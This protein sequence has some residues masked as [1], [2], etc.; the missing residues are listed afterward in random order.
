MAGGG[1]IWDGT[2]G[3]DGCD[4]QKQKGGSGK[5]EWQVARAKVQGRARMGCVWGALSSV[6]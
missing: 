1:G 2:L 5:R 6:A 4:P 3:L